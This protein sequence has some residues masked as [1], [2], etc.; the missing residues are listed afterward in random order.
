VIIKDCYIP[1]K[2]EWLL[3]KKNNYSLNRTLL[4][5]H[6]VYQTYNSEL[7]RTGGQLNFVD[8]EHTFCVVTITALST[9]KAN[10]VVLLLSIFIQFL[11]VVIVR[12]WAVFQ[13][14]RKDTVS[15]SSGSQ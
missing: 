7:S 3:R 4:A 2:R 12:K 1:T 9:Y 6:S 14:F 11:G 5:H 8:M 13:T 10:Y 15:T